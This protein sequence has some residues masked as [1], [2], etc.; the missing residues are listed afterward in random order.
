MDINNPLYDTDYPS[1]ITD[2]PDLEIAQEGQEIHNREMIIADDGTTYRSLRPTTRSISGI[3]KPNPRYALSIATSNILPP[4]SVH[5]A[6]QIPEWKKAMD[7]EILAMNEN[8]TWELIDRHPNDNIIGSIWLFKVKEKADGTLDR[9]K[10]RL[11]ANGTNQV[12]GFDYNETFSPVIKPV[13][14][15]IILAIAVTNN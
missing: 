4:K 5:Q 12:E 6:L 13:S 14:I 11:V 2:E 1:T 8:D 9:L 3:S 10:V 15:R 7:T